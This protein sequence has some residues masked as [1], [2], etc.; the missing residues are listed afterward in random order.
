M[1]YIIFVIVDE[2]D[3][4]PANSELWPDGN[5]RKSMTLTK[6][7]NK[8]PSLQLTPIMTVHTTPS[9]AAICVMTSNLLMDAEK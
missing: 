2:E 4:V 7:I 6:P 8:S 1:I 5:A 3:N 9:K